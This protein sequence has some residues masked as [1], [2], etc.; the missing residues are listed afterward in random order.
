M[1]EVPP[2]YQGLFTMLADSSSTNSVLFPYEVFQQ[3]FMQDADEPTQKLV[4]SLLVP[5]PM[6]Y[7]T[8]PVKP[9]DPAIIGVPLTY[10]LSE[11]D[12]ALPPGEYGWARF[13]DRLGVEPMMS[14][15]SH[16]ACLTR[17]QELATAFLAA[18]IG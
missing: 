10:L 2:D 3:A 18:A 1:D 5:Q 7:F 12:I 16:E 6:Q 11:D 8:A 14:P 15:G 9:I 4:H 17:P 13:A